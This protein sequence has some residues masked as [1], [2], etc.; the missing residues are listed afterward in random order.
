[1]FNAQAILGVLS[2]TQ[3]ALASVVER[4]VAELGLGTVLAVALVA[5]AWAAEALARRYL[6]RKSDRKPR[7]RPGAR[8]DVT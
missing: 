2:A 3:E 8:L 5:L 7:G 6:E 1:M 4:A